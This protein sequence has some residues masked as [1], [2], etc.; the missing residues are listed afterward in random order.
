MIYLDT[1]VLVSAFRADAFSDATLN[2]LAGDPPFIF[3]HWTLA[4]FSS[5]IANLERQ[6]LVL[7]ADRVTLERRLDGWIRDR[8]IC[9]VSG[10]DIKTARALI[11]QSRSLRAGDA[12]HLAV[13]ARHGFSL[14][15]FDD[16]MAVAARAL[17]IEVIVP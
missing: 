6:K 16:A 9:E 13:V 15:T 2:W 5:A 14:A 7:A 10:D 4:E 8:P 1:S 3:S 17:G 11:R 12:M